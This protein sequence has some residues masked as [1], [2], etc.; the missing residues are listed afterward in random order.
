VIGQLL[1][2]L[3]HDLRNP[4]SALH[5]NVGY[6][7]SALGDVDPEMREALADTLVSCDGLAHIIDN[8]E[9]LA[10]ALAAQQN[11]AKLQIDIVPLIVEA[12]ARN[13]AL[14]KSHG[15]EL[16]LD[17]AASSL[18]AR[19][20][21]H[22]EMLARALGNL[23]RNGIQHSAGAAAVR[24]SARLESGQCIVTIEDGGLPLSEQLHEEG[25]TAGGQLVAKS[26][27]GGR[28]SRGLGLFSARVSAE[29]AGAFVRVVRTPGATN[30][31]ELFLPLVS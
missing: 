24:V 28:Y 26:A 29:A 3:A 21:A 13:Q 22:R 4:L 19:V 20:Q 18:S 1:G 23:V 31:F 12:V 11:L 14:A 6:L 8:I 7:A 27:R 30:A 17:P 5:S 10:H 2:L 9:V 15:V 16:V 25:F